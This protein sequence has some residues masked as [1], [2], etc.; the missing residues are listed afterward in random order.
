LDWL[1]CLVDNFDATEIESSASTKFDTGTKL[2]MD[3]ETKL[4][5]STHC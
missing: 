3:V 1:V 2:L 4:T 5:A